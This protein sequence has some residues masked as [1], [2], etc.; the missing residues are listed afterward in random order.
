MVRPMSSK[1]RQ[2]TMEKMRREL[3]VK[4]RRALKQQKKEAA[5]LAKAAG[6]APGDEAAGDPIATPETAGVTGSE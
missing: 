1:K 6:V 4:E 3:A 2:Q 5:R